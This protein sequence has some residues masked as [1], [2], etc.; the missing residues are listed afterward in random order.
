MALGEAAAPRPEGVR[1][2]EA[3]S[4]PPWEVAELPAPPP[5]GF[6]N[7]LRV[8]GAGAIILG[9]SIG[10]GEWLI[11]PAVTA[12]FTAALLW[13]ATASILLQWVFNEEASRYTLYTGEPI[14]SGFMRTKPGSVFWGWVYSILGFIQ[15]G[16][17]G[18]AAAAATAVVAAQIGGVPGPEHAGTVKFWG[19]ITFFASLGLLLLGRKVEQ[20]LEYA[21]WFMV[22]WIVAALLF[23]GIVFTS[24]GTWVT[25]IAGFLAG[26]LYLI[27]DPNSGQLMGLIPQGADWF[28]LAGFAAYA[29]AG[30][31]GNCTVSNWVRDKGMGM[32]GLVGY[33]PAVVGGH[34]VELAATGKVFEPTPEN[35][36]TF[37]QWWRYI[38]FDQGW[39]WTVGCFLGMGLPALLTVQFIPP[40]TQIGGMAV[41]VRQ[42]EGISNAFGGLANVSGSLLWYLTLLTGFWILYST[43]LGIMDLL[44]RTVTDILWTS[45]PGVRSWSNGDV[46]KVYYSILVVFVVWGCIAINLAQPFILILLGAFTAGLMM[47]IYGI[48]VSIVNRKFLP[49]EVQ[50][51]LWR[52][53]TLWVFSG[54]FG[55]F[56]TVT[57]LDRVLGIKITDPSLGALV[58]AVFLIVF[59]LAGYV[60]RGPMMRSG[61]GVR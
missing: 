59:G 23:L 58:G 54:F 15:L 32:G 46:R 61:A 39:V 4:L 14:F 24:L 6:G 52:D 53:L 7:A 13:V 19:Y 22:I 49:P 35:V 18:W 56:T 30:G 50:A 1:V 43:Q 11:G 17:P 25:V 28:I 8:T 27:R 41:A 48:H 20:A 3:G 60:T 51:P 36:S 47:S 12:Q 26:G 34:R 9:I 21:E 38:R 57:I 33:I 44:P 42:A 31:L 2:I 45:N 5:Y 37:R 29:G 10:S 16:W 55:F 40:G